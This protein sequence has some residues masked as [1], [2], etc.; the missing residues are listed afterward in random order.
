MIKR[1]GPN[2]RVKREYLQV[3]RETKVRDEPSLDSVAKAI[4]RFEEHS[5]H[6]DFKR[7]HIELARSFK[8]HLVASRNAR[9]GEPLS[10][11]TV[12]STLTALKL[13]FGWLSQKRGYRSRLNASDAEYFNAPGNLSRVA[14]ARRHKACPTIEQVRAMLSAMPTGTEI[15]Q[16]D[17][18]LVA[19]A[20]LSGARD[21][22]I[23]SFRLKHIDSKT[24]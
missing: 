4:D 13:F 19:F 2:E 23:V 14:T 18:A 6:R 20:L 7:F 24:N 21:R 15:E 17:R 16:R 3:L 8:E 9:T 5:K 12:R 11:S 1:N 10:A 22:A